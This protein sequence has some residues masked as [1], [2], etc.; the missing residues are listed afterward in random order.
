M[1]IALLGYGK[2]G[3][4]IEEIAMERGHAISLKL[5]RT[6]EAKELLNNRTDVAIEFSLPKS[7]VRNMTACFQH[8]VPVVVG[9]TGWYDQFEEMKNA[10]KSNHGALFTASNFSLGVNIFNQMAAKLSSIMQG[11]EEYKAKIHEVHHTQKLDSPSGTA[12][13]LAKTVIENNSL[14]SSW[15]D[16]QPKSHDQLE[17]SAE[18]IGEVAGTHILNFRSQIDEIS[19]EHRAFNRKGFALGAVLAA[20]WLKG[21]K[22]IFGMK[23]LLGF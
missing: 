12:I 4:I 16:G 1:R 15:I 8:G 23:D 20:E 21:K 19:L 3:K 13:S 22:G 10:C 11:F 2:M 17:I 9:T 5:S 6:P 7:A 14:Y 18:R